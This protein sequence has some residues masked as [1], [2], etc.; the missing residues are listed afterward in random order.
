MTVW[1]GTGGQHF[2]K[3]TVNT[4]MRQDGWVQILD[5]VRPG[6]TIVTE[7]AVFLSNQLLLSDAG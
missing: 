7:G 1:V 5:G 2:V 6:E 4:G 3:R